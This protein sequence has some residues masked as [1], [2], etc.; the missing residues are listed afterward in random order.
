MSTTASEAYLE[1]VVNSEPRRFLLEADLAYSI[2]RGHQ[3]TIVLPDDKVSRSHA[4]VQKA[5]AGDYCLTDLGSRN[6]TFVNGRRVTAPVSLQPGD[7]ITMG[8]HRF[9][10]H[11]PRPANRTQWSTWGETMVEIDQR[12]ITVLVADIHDFAALS[13]RIPESR[14][15]QMM[16]ALTRESGSVLTNQSA[17]GQ[18]Y[19]GNAVMAIWLHETHAPALQEMRAVFQG[20]AGVFEIA[21]GLEARFGLDAPIRMGAGINT[22]FASIGNLGSGNLADYTALSDT[23]NR[24]LRLEAVT[25]EIGCDLALGRNT[26]EFLASQ[27]AMSGLFETHTVKLKGSD[28]PAQIFAAGRAALG[29]LLETLRLKSAHEVASQHQA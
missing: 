25:K 29:T 7:Q 8:D 6:G 11:G 26:Y 14:L 9:V 15:S 1:T 21:D 2:G 13:R 19:I 12:L 28:E 18:K 3:N 27:G 23:V 10:F 5:P 16:S 20:L 4:V 24:S 22:G 17:W